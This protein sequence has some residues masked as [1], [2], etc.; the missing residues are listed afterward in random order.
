M[1]IIAIL[2]VAGLV[3]GC[4]TTVGVTDSLKGVNV[5]L[6]QVQGPGE[7]EGGEVSLPFVGLIGAALEQLSDT[8]LAAIGRKVQV[9]IIHENQ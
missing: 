4:Q 7:L 3:L 1:R 2:I 6:G 5:Q 8:F 9:E